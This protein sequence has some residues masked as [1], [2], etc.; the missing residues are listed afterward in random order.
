[1]P[2]TM[3][4]WR[5]LKLKSASVPVLSSPAWGRRKRAGLG[6]GSSVRDCRRSDHVAML[7]ILFEGIPNAFF[8]TQTVDKGE[9]AF[10]ILGHIFA[11]GIAAAFLETVVNT[12]EA[13]VFE[14]GGNDVGNGLVLKQSGGLKMF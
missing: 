7:L 5:I 12:G 6:R 14:D 10:E 9:V 3:G 4:L 2:S 1:M 11:D 8:L 13:V